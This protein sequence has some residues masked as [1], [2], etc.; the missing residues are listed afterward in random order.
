MKKHA[1]TA[2]RMC[3]AA[4]AFLLCASIPLRSYAES[5]DADAIIDYSFKGFTLGLETGLAAGYL[6]TG[7][8]Y[9]EREWRKL[10]I[11]MGIGAFAGVTAGIFIAAADYSSRR[12][13]M[14][15]YY[16]LRDTNYG[17]LLGAAMG[18]IVGAMFWLDDGLPRDMLQGTAYGMLFGAVAGVTYGIIESRNAPR[19]S[20]RHRD[21]RYYDDWRFSMAPDPRGGGLLSVSKQF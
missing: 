11:G 3:I 19:R 13:S 21:D 17:T 6:T 1:S 12:S 18:A 9:D 15:G 4:F 16:I 2:A 14:V 5:P 8:R 7:D 10:A 20:R